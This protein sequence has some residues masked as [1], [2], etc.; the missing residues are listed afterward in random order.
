M[1]WVSKGQN[2][3]LNQAGPFGNVETEIII[4]NGDE[5]NMTLGWAFPEA[6]YFNGDN[7][8]MPPLNASSLT[9]LLANLSTS[10]SG[11]GSG[12][13]SSSSSS[14]SSSGFGQEVSLLTLLMYCLVALVFCKFA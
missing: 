14:S 6:I 8:V 4:R 10:G 12:S 2:D 7:C 11:S 3:V 9:L 13:G 1:I 5:S